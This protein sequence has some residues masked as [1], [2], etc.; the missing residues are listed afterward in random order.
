MNKY[1]MI[2]RN[3][4]QD[5]LEYRVDFF[6][7]FLFSLVPFAVNTMLWVAVAHNSST[8]EMEVGE[9]ISYYL[10]VLVTTNL[11]EAN[12]ASPV[13]KDIRVGELNKYLIKPCNYP[14]YRMMLD[15]PRKIVF[16]VM[17]LIPV[18][19]LCFLLRNY[20]VFDLSL[21]KVLMYCALI[22]TGYL[23]NFLLDFLIGCY[24][25]YFSKINSLYSSMRV[26]RN[27]LA[28]SIFPLSLLSTG[29]F[30]LLTKLP[31][32]Y[33]IFYPCSIL[34]SNTYDTALLSI[35]GLSVFWCFAL[36]LFCL[37]VWKSGLRHYSSFGG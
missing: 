7:S 29:W 9:I 10:I 35:L 4:L 19:I 37:V 22:C 25:F 31:F 28:G 33:S 36:A 1:R 5:L 26:F 11:S 24:S 6:S 30:N 2:A 12:V 14:L 3:G 16:T 20:L 8:F 21:L 18:S 32:A 34:L 13:S 23:I 27:I 15:L 17:N